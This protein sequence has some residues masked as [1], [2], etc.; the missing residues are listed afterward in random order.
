MP[1]DRH[2]INEG[3]RVMLIIEDDKAFASLLLDL[4]RKSKFKGVVSLRGREVWCLLAV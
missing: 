1:D 4:A 2:N 3:D